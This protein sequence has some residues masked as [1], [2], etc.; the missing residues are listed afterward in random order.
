MNETFYKIKGNKI[1][2]TDK[3][4]FGMGV[5]VFLLP[6][7][8][9][10]KSGAKLENDILVYLSDSWKPEGRYGEF[11]QMKQALCQ[12]QKEKVMEEKSDSRGITMCHSYRNQQDQKL[13]NSL[14]EIA[15]K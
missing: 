3:I 13:W 6:K 1:I 5:P 11:G 9:L 8:L 12:F 2:V 4:G 10:S 14:Q 15:L 7:D